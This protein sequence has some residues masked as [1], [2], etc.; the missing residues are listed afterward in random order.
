MEFVR[1]GK[2]IIKNRLTK[3]LHRHWTPRQVVSFHQERLPTSTICYTTKKCDFI[4][5][6]NTLMCLVL[7]NSI[8]QNWKRTTLRLVIRGWKQTR[9]LVPSSRDITK[10]TYVSL[11]APFHSTW[12]QGFRIRTNFSPVRLCKIERVD[13]E[14]VNI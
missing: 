3:T 8:F 1:A 11:H 2:N 5:S 14:W 12:P 13:L 10:N 4:T 9:F 6:K 7:R